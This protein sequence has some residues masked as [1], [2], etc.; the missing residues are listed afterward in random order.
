MGYGHLLTPSTGY[1]Y[2]SWQRFTGD[3]TANG[4]GSL[5]YNPTALARPS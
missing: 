4:C 1:L 2:G 5:A 3:S